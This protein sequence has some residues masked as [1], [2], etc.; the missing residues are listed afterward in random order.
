MVSR[1]WRAQGVARQGRRERQYADILARP[2]TQPGGAGCRQ[3]CP[4]YAGRGT[5]PAVGLVI[6]SWNI[7]H[8]RSHP[9][10]STLRVEEAIRLAAAD[11]PDVLCLQEVP[12]W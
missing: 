6:R 5:D 3:K 9:P 4:D 8:G 2:R 12:P 11:R 7:F 10:D 1:L